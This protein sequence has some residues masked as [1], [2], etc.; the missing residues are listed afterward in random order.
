[1][2]AHA[3]PGG[4]GIGK[5]D[6]TGLIT[7]ASLEVVAELTT[8]PGNITV[9]PAGQVIVSLHQFYNHDILV[10]TIGP[11]SRLSRFAAAANV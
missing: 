4:P 3:H 8:G 1:M 10:A 2:H 7:G 11:D 5:T 6:S 9:T